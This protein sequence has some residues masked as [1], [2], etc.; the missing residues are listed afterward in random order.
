MPLQWYGLKLA[1]N[2]NACVVTYELG[3][4]EPFLD[5]PGHLR[6]DRPRVRRTQER[7]P[8]G[9]ESGTNGRHKQQT[10]GPGTPKVAMAGDNP[11]LFKDAEAALVAHE[12]T[13]QS[14]LNQE[15]RDND[16][17]AKM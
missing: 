13:I 10:V 2:C 17:S 7:Q 8:G 9:V 5:S 15:G 4:N 11:P 16:K 14:K 6:K 3:S 1:L 12:K